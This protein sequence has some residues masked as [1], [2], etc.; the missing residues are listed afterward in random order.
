M[1]TAIKLVVL[2]ILVITILSVYFEY[3]INRPLNFYLQTALSILVIIGTLFYLVYL[4][5]CLIK[6]LNPNS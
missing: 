1:K 3:V 5:K 4:I 2:T 6:I